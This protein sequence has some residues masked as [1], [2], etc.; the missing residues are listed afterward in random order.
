MEYL[1]MVDLKEVVYNK[2]YRSNRYGNEQE[3]CTFGLSALKGK[4]IEKY[5]I[6]PI[7]FLALI[8]ISLRWLEKERL[9]SRM[10]PEYFCSLV[11]WT[12]FPLNI[13]G[14]WLGLNFSQENKTSVACLV[15]SGLNSISH[16]Y[17]HCFMTSRSW[18]KLFADWNGSH[19]I[20]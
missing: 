7:F 6:I 3:L 11:V 8:D 2:C 17:A 4:K 18:F 9:E 20:E 5:L 19:T 15:G 14:G 10:R 13:K 12:I 1:Q 16:W